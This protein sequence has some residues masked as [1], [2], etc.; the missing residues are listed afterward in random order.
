[1]IASVALPR[2]ALALD[3]AGASGSDAKSLST[4]PAAAVGG[5]TEI[6]FSLTPTL[7]T[8]HYTREPGPNGP[9][10]TSK[11]NT[12]GQVPY[13]AVRYDLG[14]RATGRLRP[15]P[16]EFG[17]GLS[18][19]APTGSSLA[20]PADGPGRY[21]L[22]SGSSFAL[23]ITPALAWRPLP[24]LRVGAGPSLV[25]GSLTAHKRI[26]LAPSLAALSPSQPPPAPEQPA[27]EGEVDVNR[28]L[29]A[30]ATASVGAI[31]EPFDELRLGIGYIFATD[32]T[33]HGRSELTPSLDIAVKA[34]GD[35]A[36]TK[37]LPPFLNVGARWHAGP[38]LVLWLEGQW[39]GWSTN[40]TSH[41]RI[42]NS[43]IRGTNAD[44]QTLLLGLGL[45][46]NQLV[47]GILNRD[48]DSWNGDRDTG[49][50]I[51]GV[52]WR[53]DEWHVRGEAGYFLSSVPIQYVTPA[54]L[55]FDSVLLG[56]GFTWA[57]E[58]RRFELG[59]SFDRYLTTRIDVRNSAY[60][61]TAAD[62]RF[63]LP[64]GNGHYEASLTKIAFFGRVKF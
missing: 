5:G 13:F 26:D 27:L 39:I 35:F 40:R 24:N 34:D 54:E 55:D 7:A 1:M 16:S 48:S 25:I 49:N 3:G 21:H 56:T 14:P 29:G 4:N 10:P 15:A 20:L 8:V 12:L 50:A 36:Y 45:T 59:A 17:V 63:Q 41:V 33:M 62:P 22:I 37:H 43:Q 30:T 23:Y 38:P 53:F 31:W 52:E 18:V 61:S 42:S 2:S 47:Q 9:Y 44:L 60:S 28:A 19:S 57:P 51:A 6:F 32:V 11:A 58:R 64:S 46:Q